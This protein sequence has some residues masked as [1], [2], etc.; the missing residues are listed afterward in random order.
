MSHSLCPCQG[1]S[2]MLVGVRNDFPRPDGSPPLFGSRLGTAHRV[3]A[4]SSM[5][6]VALKRSQARRTAWRPIAG[7]KRA[8]QPGYIE[9]ADPTLRDRAPKGGAWVHEIKTDGY[10]AQLH[11]RRGK[12]TIYSRS[13]YDWTKQFTPIATAA[14]ALSMHDL[15]IDGEATVL[16]ET[17]VPD[18]QALRRELGDPKSKRLLYHAFDLL[19]LDGYNLRPSTLLHRKEA[20]RQLLSGAPTT[21][22]FVDYL[23]EDG[24]RVFEHAC[25]LGLEGIVSKRSDA[26]YRSGRVESWI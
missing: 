19:Y 17:G 5:C 14:K 22:V 2:V 6:A 26:P 11:I 10:R 4:L 8:G 16:G 18:F 9:F 25:Q 23:R 13:G 20:L 12:I 7:A 15:I 21:F 24:H 1:A 3:G